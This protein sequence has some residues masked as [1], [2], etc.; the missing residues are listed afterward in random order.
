MHNTS[1]KLNSSISFQESCCTI[2]PCLKMLIFFSANYEHLKTNRIQP[3]LVQWGETWRSRCR[4]G[5]LP[6][7]G[8]EMGVLT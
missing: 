5:Q 6:V 4:F 7:N 8:P 1:I 2:L 3:I